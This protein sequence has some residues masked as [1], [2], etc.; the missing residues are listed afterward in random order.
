MERRLAAI[1]A[2]DVVGYGRLMEQDE[3]STFE[4]LRA[5]RKELFEPEIDRHHGRIF[6]LMGDGL[7][8]EFTSVVDVVECAVLLQREMAERNN[9]LANERRID[10]RM[11]VH[12]GDVIVEGEDRHGDA[13]IIA[14]RLQ[15]VAEPGGICV[16]GGVVSQ[17]RHKVA[18]RFDLRGEERLK[19][20]AEPVAVY[21]VATDVVA[22][23]RMAKRRH[24]PAWAIAATAAVLLAVSV[25]GAWHYRAEIQPLMQPGTPS[26]AASTSTDLGQGHSV[27]GGANSSMAALPAPNTPTTPPQQQVDQGI[28]AIIVLPFQNLT[29]QQPAGSTIDLKELGKGIAEDFTT[30]L[31]TFPDFEVISSTS[32]T[33]Y[34]D[35]PI[36]DI[37]RATGAVFVVE[38]SIRD[39]DGNL[40]VT[41]QLIN[42]KTDRHLRIAEFEEKVTEPVALQ[43]RVASRL[44]DA[45]G[46]MTGLLRKE[47]EKIA[48]SKDDAELTEYDYYI[49]GHTYHLRDET[50]KAHEIWQQA[51]QRFP[52]SVLL[53]YKLSFTYSPGSMDATKLVTEAAALK[54]RSRLDEWYSHWAAALT[55]AAGGDY[56]LAVSEARATVAMAPYDTLSHAGLA[57]IMSDAGEDADAVAWATFATTHDPNPRRWYF[58]VLSRAYG[59]AKEWPALL[60]LAESEVAGPSPNKY[61][62]QVLARAYTGT[63]QR[64]KAGEAWA[65][66]DSLPD[67]PSE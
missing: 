14:T 48:W 25:G 32:A 28:P 67:P 63:H 11:G 46:G 9:A 18:L 34:A 35:K 58:D 10:V 40:M 4:Q 62:Y 52:E 21:R 12:V 7:L 65:K 31:A 22:A 61:W 59:N 37:F 60:N 19:N 38:G 57:G 53:H 17:V 55:Y 27:S 36:P 26:P 5:H 13:V 3:A 2:V 64:D 44:R 49:R 54:K 56:K 20:V 23:K 15:Q 24:V 43:Q 30:D 6:K 29:G 51:L 33:A 50:W 66:F 16:S 39:A 41:M 45:L 1:L 47:Y 42:G 8:A